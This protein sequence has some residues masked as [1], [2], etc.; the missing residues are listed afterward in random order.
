MADDFEYCETLVREADRDRFVAA[1]FAPAPHRRALHA[2]YAFDVELSRV[3][4]LAREPMPG[5]I[6]LQ[7]W[8]D[9]LGGLRAGEA[10]PVA[11]ALLATVARYRLPMDV[12][13]AMIEAR[14][15]DLYDDPMGSLAEL[16]AYAEK[17]SSAAMSLAARILNDGN[18]PNLNEAARHAGI[19]YAI[20]GLLAAFPLHSARRQLYVPLDLMQRHAARP[21]DVFAGIATPELSAALAELRNVPRAHLSQIPI[22][23]IPAALMPAFLPAALTAPM[24]RRLEHNAGDPF[25]P[26]SLPQ[27]RRQW[28]LW[29]AARDPRRIASG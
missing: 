25:A 23:G 10:G 21:E 17:T 7:W 20:A 26:R 9:V 5:E 22:V 4:E 18:E 13:T 2:L 28:L 16:E 8:R 1:L 3:R 19:A 6:R 24:L 27:W 14:S 29:R 11:S 15:F 12:F